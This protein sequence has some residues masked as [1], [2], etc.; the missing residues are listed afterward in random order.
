MR[1]SV[2]AIFEVCDTFFRYFAKLRDVVRNI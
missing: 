1:C 2:L